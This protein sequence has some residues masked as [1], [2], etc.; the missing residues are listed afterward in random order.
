MELLDLYVKE[1]GLRLPQKQH[2]DIEKEIRSMILDALED[3]RAASG[4]NVPANDEAALTR[5]LE[6]LGPPEKV[7]ASYLPP[8]YLIGPDLYPHFIN[9]LKIVMTVV[10]IL[11]VVGLGLSMGWTTRIP[12]DISHLLGEV[13]TSLVSSLWT[14]LGV[15]VFIFAIIQRINP[16]INA[17]ASTW[18]VKKLRESAGDER[19]KT[20]EQIFDAVMTVI[21]IVFI[22]TFPRNLGFINQS[23]NFT[24]IFP[25]LTEAFRVYVPW[26]SLLLAAQ[27]VVSIV[28]VARGRWQ[29]VTRWLTIALDAVTIVLATLMLLGPDLL[30]F[31]PDMLARMAE[32]G[33]ASGTIA[34]L[35]SVMD[36]GV[37]ITLGIIIA[38]SL[39]EIGQQ[40]YRL[41]RARVPVLA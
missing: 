10:L 18:D 41:F 40:L 4:E 3:E 17:K 13:V 21:M 14:V 33:I 6:R 20:G 28:L 19:V 25:R 29:P 31:G 22:N 2:E 5:V 39:I 36:G 32:N 38:V 27:A 12:S 30:A 34:S 9:T 24:L 7:A 35:E 23:G 16:D 15:I 1:V 8:R 11:A 26:L 37:R